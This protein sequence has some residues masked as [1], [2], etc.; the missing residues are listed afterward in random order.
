MHWIGEM[1][2]RYK[3][4]GAL[5]S[6]ITIGIITSLLVAGAS[7]SSP[8][9]MPSASQLANLG[10]TLGSANKTPP[11]LAVADAAKAAASQKAGADVLNSEYAHCQVPGEVPAI[12]QDCYVEL[13]NPAQLSTLA[14]GGLV[15]W[16][17]VLVDPTTSS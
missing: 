6:I 12:D 16:E 9:A 1:M 11:G 17:V 4:I 8:S 14:G 15:Q 10:V 5:I 7:S 2:N 13:M 3:K